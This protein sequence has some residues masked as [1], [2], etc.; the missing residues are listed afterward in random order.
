MIKLYK[1]VKKIKF[2]IK[3]RVKLNKNLNNKMIN[4]EKLRKNKN[5]IKDRRKVINLHNKINHLQIRKSN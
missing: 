3:I 2:I 4:K 5:R 1:S